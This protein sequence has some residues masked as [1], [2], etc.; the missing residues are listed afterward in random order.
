MFSCTKPSTAILSPPVLQMD[1]GF[2]TWH[3]PTQWL[4]LPP[5]SHSL[6]H[7]LLHSPLCFHHH[8]HQTLPKKC[9]RH[10]GTEKQPIISQE[11]VLPRLN[12][13]KVWVA[14]LVLSLCSGHVSLLLPWAGS[15]QYLTAY[16][17]A[18]SLHHFHPCMEHSGAS[19]SVVTE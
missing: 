14:V 8:H 12:L 4:L 3:K 2:S 1:Q 9:Q 5:L 7:A 11:G 15:N 13:T 19:I 17:C 6:S 10:R 16:V 18:Y